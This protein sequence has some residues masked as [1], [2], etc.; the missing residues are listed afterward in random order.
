[1]IDDDFGIEGPPVVVIRGQYV[2]TP[3]AT[4]AVMN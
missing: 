3:A 4:Q 1:M 2:S